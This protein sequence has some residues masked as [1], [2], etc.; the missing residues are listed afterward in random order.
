MHVEEIKRLCFPQ[1]SA[2]HDL[3]PNYLS[4]LNVKSSTISDQSA[5]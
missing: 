4:I 2:V 1:F 5:F 3:D